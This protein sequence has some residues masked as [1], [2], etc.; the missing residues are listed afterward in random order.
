MNRR[1]VRWSAL[2]AIVAAVAG[3]LLAT[4]VAG[5]G[6]EPVLTANRFSLTADGYEPAVFDDLKEVTKQVDVTEYTTSPDKDAA[7][8]KVGATLRPVLTLKRGATKSRSLWGWHAAMLRGDPAGRRNV[9]LTAFNSE[10]KPV[11]RFYLEAA[12]P[13]KI[14]IGGATAGASEALIETVTLVATDIQ[15]VPL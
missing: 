7:L 10:G 2:V 11:A 14:T 13:S 8:S 12:F 5:Q 6:F 3:G 4:S 1:T 9:T 15:R